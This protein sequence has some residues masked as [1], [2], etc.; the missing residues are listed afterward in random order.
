MKA[1]NPQLFPWHFDTPLCSPACPFSLLPGMKA[2]PY[3][4]AHVLKSTPSHCLFLFGSPHASLVT[5]PWRQCPLQL[6]PH[7]SPFLKWPLM[8]GL[9][10][11]W[12]SALDFLP[13]SSSQIKP[14]VV[15]WKCQALY[16]FW[17]AEP[18]VSMAW[19]TVS[20]CSPPP[21]HHGQLPYFLS[22]ILENPALKALPPE[23][24]FWLPESK[25]GPL[26]VLSE[27]LVHSLALSSWY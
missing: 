17:T 9:N 8:I 25:T 24:L 20:P 27:H 13:L 19:N 16:F 3:S 23:S 6:P 5:A 4:S 26:Y 1:K 22:H 2:N 10:A 11:L 18:A 21:C 14:F 15:P 12:S 7:P